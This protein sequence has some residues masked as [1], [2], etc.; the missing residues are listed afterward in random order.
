M[1]SGQKRTRAHRKAPRILIVT[2]EVA[3]LPAGMGRRAETVAAKAGG[4]ADVSAGLIQALFELGADV[5]L[6][7]PNYR[8]LFH[9]EVQR[10]VNGALRDYKSTLKESRIHFAEDRAFY[11][12]DSVY[13][14][15]GRQGAAFSLILQ[16]EVINNIVP[17]VDPD[18]IHCHDWMTGLIPSMARRLGIPSLQT[19]HNIHTY[20]L[21]LAEIE[22]SGIDAA[23]FWQHLYYTRVPLGYEESRA[24]NSVDILASGIFA[25]HFVNTVSPTFLDEIVC[26]HHDF[27][28]SNIRREIQHKMEAGC[29]VGIL[30]APPRQFSPESDE[31]IERTYSA[32][33]H[34]EAKGANKRALQK[35][36]GMEMIEDGPLFFWPSR[37]DPYQK[38]PELLAQVLHDVVFTYWDRGLQVAVVGDGPFEYNF[39]DIV[40]THGI[41]GRVG[42]TPF[43]ERLSRLGYAA[44]DFI[45]MPSR[46]EPCGLPQMVGA[47]YG[48]LPVVRDTGGLRDTVKHLNVSENTGNGFV[49]ETYDAGG[50][51]WAMGQAMEFHGLPP[52]LRRAQVARVMTQAA[53]RFNFDVTARGYFDL[54][55]RMLQRPL[56]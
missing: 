34:V 46:F 2:P 25:A 51:R 35:A 49:F 33:D 30:N 12:R 38:G 45:L 17:R 56:L 28:P 52:D 10:F 43:N 55:E 53:A 18:L 22:E 3:S 36:L 23:E 4:M 39:H 15:G 21:T 9:V 54:Y 29:A 16:R 13:G 40:R 5:H 1:T 41:S 14:G 6:A 44:S 42:V 19:V 47:L 48:S 7:L 31:L 37:L 32:G 20:E 8:R 24:T 50:L 11:Y 26:G 27:V